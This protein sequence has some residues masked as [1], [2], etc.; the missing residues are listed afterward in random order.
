M[1]RQEL[2]IIRIWIKFDH[3]R[4]TSGTKN[5]HLFLILNIIKY[6]WIHF[7]FVKFGVLAVDAI[8]ETKRSFQNLLHFGINTDTELLVGHFWWAELAMSDEPNE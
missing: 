7:S 3:W 6:Y 8:A 4:N 5:P 1:T 2:F